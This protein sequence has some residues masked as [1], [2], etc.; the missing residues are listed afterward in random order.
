MSLTRLTTWSVRLASTPVALAALSSSLR[1]VGI[2]FVE[3]L[4]EP[5]P[6]LAPRSSPLPG[7]R[8]RFRARVASE[9]DSWVVFS[10]LIV[11]AKSPRASGSW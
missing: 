11:V 2:A 9:S 5:A 8:R 1:E 3:R 7:C 6:H 10:P 4:R